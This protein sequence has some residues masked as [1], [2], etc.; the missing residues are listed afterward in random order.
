MH[1]LEV[2]DVHQIVTVVEVAVEVVNDDNVMRSMNNKSH[3]DFAVT[4]V[5]VVI[6]SREIYQ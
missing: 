6:I 4:L 2:H 3:F 5:P 1:E